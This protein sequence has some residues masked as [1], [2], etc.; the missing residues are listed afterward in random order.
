MQ[1]SSL[2]DAPWWFGLGFSLCLLVGALL[3]FSYNEVTVNA[4]A[5]QADAASYVRYADNLRQHGVFSKDRGPNPQPDAYWAPGYPMFLAG[6]ATVADAT[7]LERYRLVLAVQ[8]ILGV[9]S[10]YFTGLIALKMMDPGWALLPPA[11]LAL[12]P[13]V[14]AVGQNLLTETLFG[15]LLLASLYQLILWLQNPRPLG[16]LVA[17]LLLALAWAVNP[18]S[19]FLAPGLVL[20]A[21]WSLRR[22]QSI[23]TR[24]LV[25]SLALLVLPV[26]LAFGAWSL[27]SEAAVAP[28]RLSSSDRLLK[29]LV[30]GMHSDYYAIW[31]AE[32]RDP[33][34][35]A[36]R[37]YRDIDGDFGRFVDTW[38]AKVVA[39]P[40]GMLSWY[41]LEKPRL[42]WGWDVQV[43][44]RD[45]YI[46]PVRY[47]LY[48]V[49]ETAD[50]TY[51]LMRTMHAPLLCC[52]LLGLLLAMLV[53]PATIPFAVGFLVLYI[54]LVYLCTQSD[55]RYSFPLRGPLYLL[56][57]FLAFSLM[58]YLRA[59]RR[60]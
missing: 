40:W 6:L 42:L 56:A 20:I 36:D 22:E 33:A 15:F 11:L 16:A 51:R 34:N 26:A 30:I 31:R 3:R 53:R 59:P 5:I 43:G 13:H 27:R 17:G 7:D 24:A 28:E 32:K 4:T 8:V 37:D 10:I 29:N 45:I 57:A 2:R 48:H 14:V 58:H 47:S 12:S 44:Y 35:P 21:G 50:F 54:S 41:V 23:P 25:A 46:Y 39:D 19:L 60:H 9:L 38:R 1:V 55:P 49:S 18:V 52:G